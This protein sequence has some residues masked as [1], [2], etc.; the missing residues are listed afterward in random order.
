MI[1]VLLKLHKALVGNIPDFDPPQ[2][3]LENGHPSDDLS[4][5]YMG[6]AG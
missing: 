2:Q 6:S 5:S 3:C 1:E 4:S